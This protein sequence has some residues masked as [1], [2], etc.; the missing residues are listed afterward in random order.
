MSIAINPFKYWLVRS[1]LLHTTAGAAVSVLRF[2]KLLSNWLHFHCWR[3]I[4]S[5]V[6]FFTS[7]IAHLHNRL[8]RALFSS[9]F[10]LCIWGHQQFLTA[11]WTLLPSGF[12]PPLPVFLCFTSKLPNCDWKHSYLTSVVR[13]SC[14]CCGWNTCLLYSWSL[15]ERFEHHVAIKVYVP[16]SHLESCHF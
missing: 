3:R 14:E 2:K 11:S 5:T 4:R 12:A 9:G 1:W 15:L 13:D 7:V 10:I 8:V 6:Q 16:S